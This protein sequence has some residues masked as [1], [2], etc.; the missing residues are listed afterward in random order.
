MRQRKKEDKEKEG[1][2]E[3]DDVHELMDNDLRSA[4]PSGAQAPPGY[5]IVQ[6]DVDSSRA[7]QFGEYKK[8]AAPLIARFG[9]EYLVRGG[10]QEVLEGAQVSARTVLLK[11]P[12]YARALEWYN[13][14]EYAR[15]KRLRIGA[16]TQGR[17][18]LV[19][20]RAVGAFSSA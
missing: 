8:Q 15:A 6:I 12:C 16:C 3:D 19:E 4:S 7:E 1:G 14:P 10:K 2:E 18:T 11:F 5:A 20:G 17:V 13:S 9:G